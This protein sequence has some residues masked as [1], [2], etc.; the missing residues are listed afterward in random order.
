MGRQSDPE[1]FALADA[2]SHHTAFPKTRPPRRTL[3]DIA[4]SPHH[5]GTSGATIEQMQRAADSAEEPSRFAHDR[6]W[7]D[8]PDLSQRKRIADLLAQR[9]SQ[10]PVMRTCQARII[11]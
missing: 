11:V 7:L 5:F 9:G 1:G 2:S 4:Q 8:S 10:M 3:R 6:Y